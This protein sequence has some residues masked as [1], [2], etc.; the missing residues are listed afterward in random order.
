MTVEA[1]HIAPRRSRLLYPGFI[2]S[3]ALNLLFL[4][5]V[6]AAVWHHHNVQV[7]R[8]ESGL[9]S[10]AKYLSPDRQ[11]AFRQQVLAA[12]ASMKIERDSVR[13]A[14]LNTNNILTAE[15][16]D[17]EKFRAAMAQ[18]RDV[19][20]RYKTGLNNAFADIVASITPEERK[21]LHTWREKRKPRLL[22]RKDTKPDDEEK[23]D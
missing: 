19:E 9:L 15:P 2:L 7:R 1:N 16:F 8:D 22:N 18:L 11:D 3:L 12:R 6:A 10:F 17:K 5:G 21:L 23:S 14:W 20:D 13:T 4:G